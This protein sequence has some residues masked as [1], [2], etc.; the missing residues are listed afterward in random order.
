[1]RTRMMSDP[2]VAAYPRCITGH[3][4]STYIATCSPRKDPRSVSS[5]KFNT[6][7]I[8][9]SPVWQMQKQSTSKNIVQLEMPMVV[10]GS[11][12]EVGL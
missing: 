12:S 4:R 6:S 7:D 8:K 9:Y 5:L 1:M 10:S 11:G 2:T 3:E